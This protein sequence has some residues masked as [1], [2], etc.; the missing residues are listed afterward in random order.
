MALLPNHLFRCLT[1]CGAVL[2]HG[3]VSWYRST[4]VGQCSALLADVE[5]KP[6]VLK[7]LEFQHLFEEGPTEKAYAST[8]LEPVSVGE[9]VSR[10]GE[11]RA[12]EKV[13]RD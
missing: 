7:A 2:T 1:G 3:T 4:L 10:V 5:Q 11:E 8:Q 12:A 6:L 13:P 9:D